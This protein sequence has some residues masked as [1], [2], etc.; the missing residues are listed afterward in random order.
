MISVIFSLVM[1]C[2]AQRP[3]TPDE[4]YFLYDCCDD[5]E[6]NPD[7]DS[8]G[9]FLAAASFYVLIGI[10]H[11]G[12]VL[13][14]KYRIRSFEKEIQKMSLPIQLELLRSLRDFEKMTGRAHRDI[15]QDEIE[16]MSPDARS[17]FGTIEAV[18]DGEKKRSKHLQYLQSKDQSLGDAAFTWVWSSLL[19]I[20]LA[21]LA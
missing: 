5:L 20:G 4:Q 18:F 2:F 7:A 21:A 17:L 10:V 15:F 19:M 14:I 6:I 9:F 16:A 11:I 12:Y 1:S 13:F 3:L 8:E